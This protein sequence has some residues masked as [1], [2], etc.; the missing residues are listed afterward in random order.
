MENNKLLTSELN[1][2]STDNYQLNANT[3]CVIVL[4][5]V[6][7]AQNIGSVFRTCDGFL[8]GKIFLCG[9]T[10]TPPNREISKTAIGA[11]NSVP[12]EYFPDAATL[13]NH[14]KSESYAIVCVEQTQQS[15]ELQTFHAIGKIALV[16]G[17]EVEGVSDAFIQAADACV[18]IPQGGSKHSLNISVTAGIVLWE[19]LGKKL[20]IERK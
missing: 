5:N 4:D 10:A 7:S 17:N 16:F 15:I 6:R 9:I 18:E 1:R 14:L 8:G 20:R 19:V 3:N 12:W 13:I 11:E 2:L